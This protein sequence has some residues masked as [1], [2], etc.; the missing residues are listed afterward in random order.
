MDLKVEVVEEDGYR[1]EVEVGRLYDYHRA[2]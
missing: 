2:R 1:G